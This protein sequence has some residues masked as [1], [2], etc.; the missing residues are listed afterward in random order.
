MIQDILTLIVS[1]TLNVI[2]LWILARKKDKADIKTTELSNVEK[3]IE[4]YRKMVED[5]AARLDVLSKG[6]KDLQMEN[7]ALLNENKALRK[8]QA[9]LE[10]EIKILKA[11]KNEANTNTTQTDIA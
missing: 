7:E 1:P 8:R 4:I 10:K 11:R 2:L 5:L 6:L 9:S 3:S